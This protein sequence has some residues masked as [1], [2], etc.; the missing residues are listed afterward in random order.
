[1][2]RTIVRGLAILA[3]HFICIYGCGFTGTYDEVQTHQ[4]A[5]HP[6]GSR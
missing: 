1:M 4:A 6:Y 5:A 3:D 2:L